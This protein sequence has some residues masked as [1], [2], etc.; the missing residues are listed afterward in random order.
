MQTCTPVCSKII[1]RL[2]CTCVCER[3]AVSSLQ[4]CLSVPSARSSWGREGAFNWVSS[5]SKLH[6]NITAAVTYS[7]IISKM[8][9]WFLIWKLISYNSL[10]IWIVMAPGILS[11]L[12]AALAAPSCMH[13]TNSTGIK[14]H[15]SV[16]CG[17]RKRGACNGVSILTGTTKSRFS[18]ICS[19]VIPYPNGTKFT[20][21]LASTQGRP[22]FKF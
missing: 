20:V 21:E 19:S 4:N 22:D 11:K 6:N 16:S 9:S 1:I 18:R 10:W 13:H 5:G 3:K 17:P 14:T 2:Q 12:H 7:Y 8:I 15:G